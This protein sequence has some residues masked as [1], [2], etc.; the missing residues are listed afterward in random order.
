[1]PNNRMAATTAAE[2]DDQREAMEEDEEETTSEETTEEDDPEAEQDEETEAEQGEDDPE[3]ST[4]EEAL[5]ILAFC[6]RRG[7]GLAEARDFITRGLTARQAID[8]VND[9][10]AR[11]SR[12]PTRGARAQIQRDERATRREG[13]A[14]AIHAQLARRRDVTGPARQFMGMSLVEMAALCIGHTGPLRTAGDRQQVLMA[15]SHSTSDFPAIFE[16]ALNKQLLERYQAAQPTYREVARQKN[17]R[18]FRPMPLVRVGDFPSLKPIGENGEIKWGT[19][20]ESRE[21]AAISSFAIGLTF[22]RQMLIND[23]LGAID[24]LV[25]SYGE[26]VARDEE[27][28][29]YAFALSAVMSDGKAIFHADHGNL[30]AANAAIGAASVSLGR[31]AIRKQK[32][33]DGNNLNL[34]PSI[35]LVGPDKET[36]A[37]M[38]LAEITPTA[39]SDVNP[40]SGRL[41]PVVTAEIAGNAWYLLSSQAPCWVYGFLEGAEA[42]RLRTEEPFGVQGFSMTLEHDFGF[43]AADYRGGYKNNGA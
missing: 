23:D 40:F 39:A 16:N 29:F 27:R 24:E 19:F 30:A 35:L 13:M 42:P 2:E 20:G 38:L 33:I 21:V 34:S 26:T 7:L 41:R 3:A 4:G 36:E 11:M 15:A 31:A 14:G 10:E 32:S 12:R 5:A 22:S 9:K 43:G 1:M 8:E 28:M 25:S 37:E 6:Q 17:F 18:D